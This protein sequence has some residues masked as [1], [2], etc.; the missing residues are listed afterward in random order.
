MDEERLSRML[1]ELPRER[2]LEGF[3]ARVLERINAVPEQ[4]RRGPRHLPRLMLAAAALA[5]IGLSAGLLQRDLAPAGGL[6]HTSA[7]PSSPVS[8]R[9][10][11]P[12]DG[13]AAAPPGEAPR[14]GQGAAIGLA[15]A[16]ASPT[17]LTSAAAAHQV[18]QELRELRS[19]QNQ[20]ERELRELRRPAASAQRSVIYLGGDE[21][22]DLVLDTRRVGALPGLPGLI[23]A[24]LKSGGSFH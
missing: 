14:A 24:A 15:A 4:S 20:L 23:G 6:Q 2:A 5:A 17:V 21:D 7:A 9:E 16:Q 19:E 10:L 8:T 11:S 22:V 13:A 3:T 18:R 12:R 1:R